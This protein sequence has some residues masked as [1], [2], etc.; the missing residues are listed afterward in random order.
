MLSTA[1]Y[2]PGISWFSSRFLSARHAKPTFLPEMRQIDDM[3]IKVRLK[4]K[5]RRT[6]FP[7]SII[8]YI[9]NDW[10][11]FGRLATFTDWFVRP[12]V[13]YDSYISLDGRSSHLGELV[14][15]SKAQT[16]I[17]HAYINIIPVLECE[18]MITTNNRYWGGNLWKE[19][20][21]ILKLNFFLADSVVEILLVVFSFVFLESCVFSWSTA[22]FLSRFLESYTF[23]WSTAYFLSIF[24]ESYS[25][26]LDLSSINSHLWLLFNKCSE[27]QWT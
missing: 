5:I 21:K 14:L 9:L 19:K 15:I 6:L 25:F 23:S 22:C 20:S 7:N 13:R 1:D 18:V 4:D 17:N 16:W 26:S 8:V 11:I 27:V 24:L 10:L 12:S 3:I 2:T